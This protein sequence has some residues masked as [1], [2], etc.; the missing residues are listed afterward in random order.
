M[1]LVVNGDI[2]ATVGVKDE[3]INPGKPVSE[4]LEYPDEETFTVS[5]E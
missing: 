2:V 3:E 5:G 1:F 4:I